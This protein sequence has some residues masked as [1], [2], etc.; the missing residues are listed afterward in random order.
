MLTV[1]VVS[2]NR[3]SIN[4][5]FGNRQFPTAED[6]CG[7]CD[8]RGIAVHRV[9]TDASQMSVAVTVEARGSVRVAT[10][11]CQHSIGPLEL[12]SIKSAALFFSRKTQMADVS[13]FV[14]G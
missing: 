7:W 12:T 11:G 3:E 8:E 13:A 6:C 5:S 1:N 14:R 10:V 2:S 4:A 9:A